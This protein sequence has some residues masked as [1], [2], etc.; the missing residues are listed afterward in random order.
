MKFDVE[1]WNILLKC[2]ST[3]NTCKIEVLCWTYKLK[4]STK[5]KYL[6]KFG[7]CKKFRVY[8]LEL[9]CLEELKYLL[10]WTFKLNLI[11]KIQYM[12][13]LQIEQLKMTFKDYI[14]LNFVKS[15]EYTCW[16]F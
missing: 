5:L 12:L 11:I 7:W 15:L 8:M 9:L 14:N 4:L 3:N 16:S 13:D 10:R 1:K 6:F 2:W